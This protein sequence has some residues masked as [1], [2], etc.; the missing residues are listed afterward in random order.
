MII[1]A[2]AMQAI[3]RRVGEFAQADVRRH[4]TGRAE[5]LAYFFRG[6]V[7][8]D[9]SRVAADM[10]TH[11]YAGVRIAAVEPAQAD[12]IR[13]ASIEA[14]AKALREHFEGIVD[15]MRDAESVEL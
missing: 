2:L 12:V 5:P 3:R 8:L 13:L 15:A 11:E 10:A 14:Y 9:I 1:G 4:V 7:M 6:D